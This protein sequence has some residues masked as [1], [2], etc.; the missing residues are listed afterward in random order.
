MLFLKSLIKKY[1]GRIIIEKLFAVLKQRYNLE[2]SRFYCFNKYKSYVMWTL[3]A[4]LIEK[5][6]DQKKGVDSL[7][8]PWNK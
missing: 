1:T 2:N 7:K 3:L 5:L 6:I 8:F 4:Y